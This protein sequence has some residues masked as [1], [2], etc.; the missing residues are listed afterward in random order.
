MH[1]A[2]LRKEDRADEIVMNHR[3]VLSSIHKQH[4]TLLLIFR[5]L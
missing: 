1:T 4:A 2:A 5:G 3:E